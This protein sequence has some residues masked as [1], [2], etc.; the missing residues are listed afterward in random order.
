MKTCARCRAI[1]SENL[2]MLQGDSG[3]PLVAEMNGRYYQAGVVSFYVQ[4]RSSRQPSGFGRVSAAM[5]WIR[6]HVRGV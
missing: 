2:R 5:P 3:G 6:Q 1:T 4:G